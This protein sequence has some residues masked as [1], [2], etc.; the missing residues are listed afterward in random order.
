MD[1][2]MSEEAKLHHLYESLKPTFVEKIWVL[3]P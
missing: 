1:P 2:N 3:Q